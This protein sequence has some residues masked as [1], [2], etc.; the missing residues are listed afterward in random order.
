MSIQ[1]AI[2]PCVF[3]SQ[4]CSS[5]RSSLRPCRMTSNPSQRLFPPLPHYMDTGKR[6]LSSGNNTWS[7]KWSKKRRQKTPED[8]FHQHNRT[9]DDTAG[10]AGGGYAQSSVPEDL[11]LPTFADPIGRVLAG[12]VDLGIACAVGIGSGWLISAITGVPDLGSWTALA[13]GT[14][15]WIGRD[16]ILDEGNRSLG[17]ILYDIEISYWDGQLARRTDCVKRNMPYVLVPFVGVHEY[18]GHALLF[19]IVWD[20]ATHLV[21]YDARKLGDYLSGTYVVSSAPGRDTRVLDMIEQEELEEIESEIES[22]SE[23]THQSLQ[24]YKSPYD[25][26]PSFAEPES[27]GSLFVDEN[28]I[29]KIT[30]PE[31]SRSQERN[32]SYK[33]I[34]DKH[35][36]VGT[37]NKKQQEKN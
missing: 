28:G 29:L 7:G 18:V 6:C 27:G 37:R 5:F 12:A 21:T 30:S 35:E 2:R 24:V 17:K 11:R 4:C 19:C 33:D 8:E 31:E 16:G 13:A 32:Q 15:A 36:A 3:T 1:R 26:D 34:A 10:Y 14:F 9:N 25:G 20:L 23:D 22:V